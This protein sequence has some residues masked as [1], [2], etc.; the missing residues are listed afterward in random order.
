MC[1][2]LNHEDSMQINVCKKNCFRKK[3]VTVTVLT[4]EVPEEGL[5]NYLSHSMRKPVFE[6]CDANQPAKL[7]RLASLEI[8]AI[9]SRDIILSRQQTTKALIRLRRCTGLSVPLLFTYGINRFSHDMAYLRFI[10][11]QTNKSQTRQQ[12]TKALIGLRGCAGW[13][14]PLL[15]AYG[16]N[17]FSHDK[18]YLVFKSDL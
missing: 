15:L 6:V 4:T 11:T 2:T 17:R 16:M 12:T 10:K 7:M 18:A 8:L 9:A 14:V 5:I 1:A 3:T 13:S